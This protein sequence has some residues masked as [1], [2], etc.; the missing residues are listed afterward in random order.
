[1][2][3]FFHYKSA[4]LGAGPSLLEIGID[5]CDVLASNGLGDSSQNLGESGFMTVH[6]QH[7]QQRSLIS[8]DIPF[9]SQSGSNPA[10]QPLPQADSPR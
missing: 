1:M 9:P 2:D 6:P 5:S 8:T 10:V 7:L 4:S 3:C